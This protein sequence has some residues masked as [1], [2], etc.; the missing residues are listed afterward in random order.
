MKHLV[1]L[2]ALLVTSAQASS[3][4]ALP[5]QSGQHT[6]QHRFSEHPSIPS[7]PLIA[8]ISGGR[9]VLVNE[10]PSDVF[11]QGIVA[12][13]TLMWHAGS[14]QWIIGHSSADQQAQDVGGCSDG[15]EVVDLERKVYWTC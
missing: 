14:N 2:A 13:G 4:P 5:I 12:E 9:I 6:F 1:V 3:G 11:P 8:K 15:P 10:T 7:I